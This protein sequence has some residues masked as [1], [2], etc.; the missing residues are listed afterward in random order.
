MKRTTTQEQNKPIVRHDRNAR[1]TRKRPRRGVEEI[2]A[3]CPFTVMID[4]EPTKGRKKGPKRRGSAE[5]QFYQQLSPFTPAGRFKT[6]ETLDL[7]Y[8]VEPSAEWQEMTRYNSFIRKW[9]PLTASFTAGELHTADTLP[10]QSTVLSTS[11]KDLS[12]WRTM[13]ALSASEV[14]ARITGLKMT[15]LRVS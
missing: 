4:K 12:T 3:D 13:P 5:P 15:G 2:H 10:T 1:P 14:P 7:N 8:S 6:T 11:V 9:P